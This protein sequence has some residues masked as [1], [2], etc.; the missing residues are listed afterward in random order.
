MELYIER[1]SLDALLYY[2]VDR[3]LARVKGKFKGEKVYI[4]KYRDY[5]RG[6]NGPYDDPI[7]KFQIVRGVRYGIFSRRIEDILFSVN[8]DFVGDYKKEI[9]CS[10]HDPKLFYEALEEMSTFINTVGII[11]VDLRASF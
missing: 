6:E 8:D 7:I 1:H 9:V 10:A 4:R 11:K 5:R 3:L 2:H